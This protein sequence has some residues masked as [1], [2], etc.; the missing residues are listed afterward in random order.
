MIQSKENQASHSDTAPIHALEA[1][2]RVVSQIAA[3]FKLKLKIIE[4]QDTGNLNA[5]KSYNCLSY[6]Q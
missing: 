5:M 4:T 1:D 2:S 3:D 6:M